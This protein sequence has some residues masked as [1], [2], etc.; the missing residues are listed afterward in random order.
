MIYQVRD[1]F[2]NIEERRIFKNIQE[3]RIFKNIEV[4][5]K[6]L[7]YPPVWLVKRLKYHLS[8]APTLRTSKRPA[9]LVFIVKLASLLIKSPFVNDVV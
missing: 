3:T 8:G 5:S 6:R 7:K 2:K 1:A 9:P 4:T